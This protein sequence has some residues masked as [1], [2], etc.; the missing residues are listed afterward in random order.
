M[1][2]R[3][4]EVAPEQHQSGH[5]RGADEKAE[6]AERLDAAKDAEKHPKGTAAWSRRR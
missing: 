2:V 5:D 6:Q 1:I 3:L 4:A